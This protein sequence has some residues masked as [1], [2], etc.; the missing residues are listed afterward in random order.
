M[1]VA[2]IWSPSTRRSA[3]WRVERDV[4]RD[5]AFPTVAIREQPVLVVHQF[6]A[7]FGR[8]FE[9]RAF[10]DGIHGAGL[11]AET[12]IDALRHVDVVA[13]GAAR[14]VIAAGARLDGD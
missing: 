2:I 11:L 7:R 1:A 13:R 8:E 5:L 9:V 6:F 14:A 12:A 10:D 3:V 4:G